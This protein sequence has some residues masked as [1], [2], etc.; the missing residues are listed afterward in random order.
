MSVNYQEIADIGLGPGLENGSRDTPPCPPPLPPLLS[1]TP[2]HLVC[3]GSLAGEIRQWIW[4]NYFC[5]TGNG[6][7]ILVT[8]AMGENYLHRQWGNY[9]CNTGDGEMKEHWRQGETVYVQ[10]LSGPLSSA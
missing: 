4:P 8:Q 3:T 6:E 5:G 1:P 9:F 7:I 10:G 2:S